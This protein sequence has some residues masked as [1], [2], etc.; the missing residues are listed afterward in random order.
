MASDFDRGGNAPFFVP[1][2]CSSIA[3]GVFPINSQF[4]AFN[5]R[6]D[7]LRE[8]AGKQLI[9]LAISRSKVH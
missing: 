5:S 9:L 4:G 2:W 7:A 1:Y 6:L 3:G 8:F